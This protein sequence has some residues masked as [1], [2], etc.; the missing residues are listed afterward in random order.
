MEFEFE[1]KYRDFSFD[2]NK[3]KKYQSKYQDKQ[4]Q[5]IILRL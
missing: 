1:H 5:L 2:F 4:K 3:I